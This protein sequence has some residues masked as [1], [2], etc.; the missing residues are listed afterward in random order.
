[1][2]HKTALRQSILSAKLLSVA[3]TLLAIIAWRW[4][5]VFTLVALGILLFTLIGDIINIIYVRRKAFKD[6]M[7]LEK[8]IQ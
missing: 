6:S 8:K 4:S 2:K 5:N 7:Y 1:M 3:V